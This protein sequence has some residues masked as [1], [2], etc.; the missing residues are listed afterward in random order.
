MSC[1][2]GAY[3]GKC[4]ESLSFYVSCQTQAQIDR[5]FEVL[6]LGGEVQPAAG[7]RIASGFRGSSSRILCSLSTK[8]PILPLPSG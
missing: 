4:H 1:S 3:F 2:G 6:S 5:L 8:A 7:S